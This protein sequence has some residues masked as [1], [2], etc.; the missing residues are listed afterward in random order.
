MK[1]KN[2]EFKKII[3]EEL[4]QLLNEVGPMA[5]LW[6]YELAN[7]AAMGLDSLAPLDPTGDIR[8]YSID[9]QG[10]IYADSPS[11]LRQ[12]RPD[13]VG[14]MGAIERD[15]EAARRYQD[16]VARGEVPTA[17]MTTAQQ[18]RVARVQAAWDPPQQA[19]PSPAAGTAANVEETA[20]DLP[21][22]A[23][24]APEP[25]APA[26]RVP[27]VAPRPSPTPQIQP[28]TSLSSPQ[29]F[30]SKYKHPS[31]P[32]KRPGKTGFIGETIEQE[33]NRILNGVL[34]K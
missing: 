33:I 34:L 9:A 20:E 12:L 13:R 10:R 31:T 29:T 2:S 1:I 32:I 8:D 23:A 17:E 19:V 22:P 6:A 16:M 15:Y 18:E 4:K 24:A 27:A 25:P 5:A 30:A 26:P 3:Q 11:Y 7:L 21:A 28:T 14:A